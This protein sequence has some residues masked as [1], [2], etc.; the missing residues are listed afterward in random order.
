MNEFDNQKLSLEA[1]TDIASG[2]ADFLLDGSDIFGVKAGVDQK[3]SL[4][5]LNVDAE[6]K[7]SIWNNT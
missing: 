4:E 3:V 1:L 2:T 6:L 7:G 5:E